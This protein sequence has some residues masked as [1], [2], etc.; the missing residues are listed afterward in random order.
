H[1]W[2]RLSYED[3]LQD[4]EILKIIRQKLKQIPSDSLESNEDKADYGL[5]EW[6]LDICLFELEKMRY[7]E[8]SPRI[9][10]L[11]LSGLNGLL[12]RNQPTS[13]VIANAMTQ[14][15]LGIPQVIADI[16]DRATKPAQLWVDGEIKALKTLPK[17]IE[18]IPSAFTDINSRLMQELKKAVNTAIDAIND[19][20]QW[21]KSIK[22]GSLPINRDLYEQ[23]TLKRRLGLDAKEIEVLGLKYLKSTEEKLKKLVEDLPGETIQE[24]RKNIRKKHAPSFEA[25]LSEYRDIAQKAQEFIVANDILTMPPNLEHKVVYTPPPMRHLMSLAGASPPGKYEDPQLGY[26][27]V[28]PH[29]DLKML[30]EHP[31]AWS[32]L[33]M[34]HESF[35][36]HNLQT[37][38]ANTYLSVVRTR[39]F[40]APSSNLG[41]MYSGQ[42]A[43]II[44]GWALYCEQMMLEKGFEDNPSNPN[45][46]KQFILYNAIRW[47]AARMV[48]DV[49]L[50]T[51]HFS[52]EEAVEFLSN[53]TGFSN[54]I[55]SAEVLMYSQSPGYFFSYL[56]GKHLLVNLKEELQISDKEFH[57]KILYCGFVPYWFIKEHIF[58]DYLY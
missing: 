24:V 1:L 5:F 19:Y 36:G 2:P 20:Q 37:I 28:C 16:K 9:S 7:W 50:H 14:R 43:E 10:G 12:L 27:W 21:L 45:P 32:S 17:F 47:R 34:S 48:I 22:G 51:G 3:V 52:Y 42:L 25:L 15:L 4:I 38:C 13:K 39:L 44:E 33:L 30:E 57:D 11:V 58:A 55:T 31:H 8:S 46:E 54:T 29:N 23:L 35:P 18:T 53:A 26:F 40:A 56:T 6:Y 49:R 41:L